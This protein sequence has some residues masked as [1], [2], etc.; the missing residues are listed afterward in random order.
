MV[1]SL[2]HSLPN[3]S[4]KE[5]CEVP[6]PIIQSIGK[7]VR[8]RSENDRNVLRDLLNQL[9]YKT[10]NAQSLQNILSLARHSIINLDVFINSLARAKTAHIEIFNNAHVN[11]V[12]DPN[13]NEISL[14]DNVDITIQGSLYSHLMDAVNHGINTKI[15]TIK[16]TQYMAQDEPILVKNITS[17]TNRISDTLE[18]LNEA[19]G[20]HLVTKR[21]NNILDAKVRLYID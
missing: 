7:I 2:A 6:P 15:Q 11:L 20:I 10:Q 17:S 9:E 5:V 21:T 3:F 4:P 12:V 16:S 14:T 8:S 19:E 13:P 18:D 1:E